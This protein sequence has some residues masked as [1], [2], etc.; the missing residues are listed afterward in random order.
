MKQKKESPG[1]KEKCTQVSGVMK[2]GLTGGI[3]CGK[4]EVLKMFAEKGWQ[5]RSADEMV[6]NLLDHDE[7]VRGAIAEK[8]GKDVINEAGQLDKARMADI[9]FQNPGRR[10]WLE[11]L[12]HPL[13]REG[14]TAAIAQAPS[15]NWIVEIPLLFEK[16]LETHFDLVVCLE[17]SPKIQLQRLCSRGLNEAD[18]RARISS[19]APL[20]EKIEKSDIVLSNNGSLNFL[21][22]QVQL[23]LLEL[24]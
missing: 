16:K 11:D 12:L 2:V 20:S 7:K 23:L 13:V 10:K 21:R 9:V 3:A 17:C 14:W 6:H 5:T 15:L 1:L 18:A 22:K 19:Q 4:S 24:G 8:F